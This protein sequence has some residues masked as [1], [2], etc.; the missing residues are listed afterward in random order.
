MTLA[1]ASPLV[2]QR[3]RARIA[4]MSTTG[5]VV[6]SFVAV[7]VAYWLYWLIAVPLIEPGID[8]RT[9]SSATDDQ[10]HQ[11][12]EATSA[13]KQ[14]LAA[15][16]PPGSWELDNPAIW[17]TDTTMLL[18]KTPRPLPDGQLELR[19]CTM[20]F[21]PRTRE[22][23]DSAKVRP[24]VMRAT[25]GATLRFDEPIVMKNVDLG[26]RQL[27][28]GHL[29]GLITIDRAASRP[30]AADDLAITTR[31][32]EL[33]GDRAFSPHPVE[34][35]MGHSHGSGRDLEILLASDGSGPGAGFRSG[36]VRALLLKRDVV[37]YLAMDDAPG[38]AGPAANANKPAAPQSP[39][40]ITCQGAFQYDFMHYAASFHDRVDVVRPTLGQSDVLNCELLTVFFE[41][42]D[43]PDQPAKPLSDQPKPAAANGEGSQVSKLP[44]RKIEA[45]RRAGDAGLASPW[46]LHPVPRTR[47]LPGPGRRDRPHGG[48]RARRD[49]GQ[50]A[51]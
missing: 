21:F 17:E 40:K 13:R 3:L 50:R 43:Q 9:V 35:R 12:R 49:A 38:G 29:K 19:H 48:H 45:A 36:K 37:M 11:A 20:L 44:V 25:E 5:Q 10:I 32:I 39:V 1:A 51:K 2:P 46:H 33:V 14:A 42:P 8:P 7:L 6:G 27:V 18:F 15:Y 34:F 16:F 22:P 41:G 47:L 26:K 28:G 31:D 23:V 4:S 24:I 30:G